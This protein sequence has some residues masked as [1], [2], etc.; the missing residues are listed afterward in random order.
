MQEIFEG[1]P[2]DIIDSPWGHIERWRAS[3]LSTGTMGTLQDVYDAVR[4]D[5]AAAKARAD[6]AEARDALVR[7][8]CSKVADFEHRFADLEDRLAA[9]EDA[10]RADEQAAREFE[11][12]PLTEPPDIH[13]FQTRNPPSEIG[14]EETHHPSG[15]LH[16]VDPKEEDDNV[17]DLPPGL[18]EPPDT[19]PVPS[20]AVQPQPI[21]I[22]L[23]ED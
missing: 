3:T 4:A 13:E 12:E 5:S 18:E 11:E 7:N 19:I 17:G 16:T 21:S 14:D 20:G 1:S 6:E 9:A 15:D 22:S 8:L 10:R 2:F 23:N